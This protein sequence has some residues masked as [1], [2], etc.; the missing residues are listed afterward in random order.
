MPFLICMSILFTAGFLT[1]VTETFTRFTVVGT[2]RDT[3]KEFCLQSLQFSLTAI[4]WAISVWAG[5]H[6]WGEDVSFLFLAECLGAAHLPLLVYPIA[7]IP[8]IGYRLAQILRFL[9]YLSFTASLLF[10]TSLGLIRA[11]VL[12]L[13]GWFFHFVVNETRFVKRDSSL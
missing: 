12:C 8:T 3:V 13:P 2:F 4:F 5:L 9:V 10:F 6:W 7:I 1:V 11:A